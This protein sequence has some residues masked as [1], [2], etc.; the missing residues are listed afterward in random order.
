MRLLILS[1]LAALALGSCIDTPNADHGTVSQADTNWMGEVRMTKGDTVIR[2]CGNGK[3]YRLSGPDM[4][5]LAFRYVHA[6]MN[7]GQA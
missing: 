5:T 1:A 3:T 7:T 2:I 6:R 4:D